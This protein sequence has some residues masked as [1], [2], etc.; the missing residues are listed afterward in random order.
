[1]SCLVICLFLLITFPINVVFGDGRVD[2]GYHLLEGK[3]PW[4]IEKGTTSV[5][6]NI[7]IDDSVDVAYGVFFFS[8]SVFF[9]VDARG[10][11]RVYIL[12]FDFVVYQ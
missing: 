8:K 6:V 7:N 5:D 1:V 2:E 10:M 11:V 4:E 3:P 12:G 9:E